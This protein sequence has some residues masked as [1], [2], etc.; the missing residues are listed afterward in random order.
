MVNDNIN[1][2]LNTV[3]LYFLKDN[4]QYEVRDQYHKNFDIF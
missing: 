3:K 2:G 4:I 1:I